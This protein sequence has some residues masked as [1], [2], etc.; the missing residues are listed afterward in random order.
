MQI[1][2]RGSIE[3]FSVPL[4][5]QIRF[6]FTAK[7]EEG[8]HTTLHVNIILGNSNLQFDSEDD[9]MYSRHT[10]HW[11]GDELLPAHELL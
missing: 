7:R 8:R 5:N 3:A 1:S 9:A 2:S 6:T 11:I 10:C 4:S